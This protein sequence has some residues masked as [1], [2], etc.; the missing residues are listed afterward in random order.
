MKRHLSSFM[1][2]L[3]LLSAR[4]SSAN[5]FLRVITEQPDNLHVSYGT[6]FLWSGKMPF[7]MA[8][9]YNVEAN[10]GRLLTVEL[11]HAVLSYA[12]G[13]YKGFHL[14]GSDERD[15]RY[16]EFRAVAALHL[17]DSLEQENT[18][19]YLLSTMYVTQ[20]LS[21]RRMFSLRAGY[22]M[23]K[24]RMR[25]D[26]FNE[27]PVKANSV[28]AG[29]SW[30][31]IQTYKTWAVQYGKPSAYRHLRLSVDLL[32]LADDT[33]FTRFGGEVMP[34]GVRAAFTAR[35]SYLS[36]RAETGMLPGLKGNLFF[37]LGFGSKFSWRI[38]P[39]SPN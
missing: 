22:D 35:S 2:L 20:P 16:A 30:S 14:L 15:Y 17:R 11:Y 13:E 26:E 21:V 38:R 28:F 1:L 10:I 37:T 9:H 6:H 36:F 32:Y 29:V 33:D 12:A 7:D 5:I 31:R 3:F 39:L 24:G 27:Y 4:N 19:V 23:L 18:K 8:F 25:F 34:L